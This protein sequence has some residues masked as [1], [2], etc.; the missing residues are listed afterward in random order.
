MA[1]EPV[2]LE[3]AVFGTVIAFLRTLWGWTQ[4]E[5]AQRCGTHESQVSD[6][7]TGKV[8]P[9]PSSVR[10]VAKAMGV[11]QST[12]YDLQQVLLGYLTNHPV[13]FDSLL[14][15]SDAL[16]APKEV[17]EPRAPWGGD[18]SQVLDERWHALAQEK[19]ALRQREV[20]LL[21]DTL[22]E[23]LGGPAGGSTASG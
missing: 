6:W 10:K 11:P 23:S 16:Q 1:T 19:A 20:L 22:L 3:K 12:L 9:R 13:E 7:E 5:L 14:R 4:G 21:R 2:Q 18:A 8:M 17:R 15:T